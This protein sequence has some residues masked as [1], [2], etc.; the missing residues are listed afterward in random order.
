MSAPQ[1][2]GLDS[3][4][5]IAQSAAI[6]SCTSSKHIARAMRDA[7]HVPLFNQSRRNQSRRMQRRCPPDCAAGY[8]GHVRASLLHAPLSL[9]PSYLSAQSPLASSSGSSGLA[10]SSAPPPASA[11]AASSSSASSARP[12]DRAT[13]GD[14]PAGRRLSSSSSSSSRP[15]PR[16][17][18]RSSSSSSSREVRPPLRS[19]RS[20]PERT[21]TAI[22]VRS[23]SVISTPYLRRSSVRS[24]S[25]TTK[26][27]ER[28]ACNR[29]A[30]ISWTLASSTWIEPSSTRW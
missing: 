2:K 7:A 26:L 18:P 29:C 13:G 25:A 4:T 17:R 28:R 20:P 9:P 5:G 22:Q 21:S 14:R 30:M 16:P 23:L 1:E 11:S 15:R 10:S 3:D 27:R 24:S 19:P 12:G 6:S 8:A